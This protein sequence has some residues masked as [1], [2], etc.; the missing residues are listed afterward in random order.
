MKGLQLSDPFCVKAAAGDV[1]QRTCHSLI[2]KAGVEKEEEKESQSGNWPPSIK[3]CRTLKRTVYT[4]TLT[5]TLPQLL[6][7]SDLYTPAISTSHYWPGTVYLIMEANFLKETGAHTSTEK[8]QKSSRRTDP[9]LAETHSFHV[10][11]WVSCVVMMTVWGRNQEIEVSVNK[12]I[13]ANRPEQ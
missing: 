9:F 10:D 3:R 7:R 6:V 12:P 5:M 2:R 8:L 4:H 11:N 1:S 13:D